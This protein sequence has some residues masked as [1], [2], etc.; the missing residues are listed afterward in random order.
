MPCL[1]YTS[2]WQTPIVPLLYL[3]SAILMG[4]GV[5]LFES[6]LASAAYRREIE[7]VLLGCLA[8]LMLERTFGP[9]IALEEV[10]ETNHNPLYSVATFSYTL[11][12]V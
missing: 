11:L 12:D 10:R 9:E 1:L 4:Y 3:L 2:L 6:C 5:V 8:E 7:T